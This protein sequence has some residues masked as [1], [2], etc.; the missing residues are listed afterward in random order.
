[1]MILDSSSKSN[2]WAK[3]WYAL[4]GY[5]AMFNKQVSMI[6]DKIQRV[7]DKDDIMTSK[8]DRLPTE[9]GNK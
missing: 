5:V 1:M 7:M 8:Y 3:L 9:Y 4:M 2:I 6:D